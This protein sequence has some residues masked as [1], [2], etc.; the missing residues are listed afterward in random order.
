MEV[1]V[2]V[3]TALGMEADDSARAGQLVEHPVHREAIERALLFLAHDRRKHRHA[4][5][6]EVDQ[7]AEGARVEE[8]RAD[9]EQ[10]P[11]A[12]AGA[13]EIDP[14]DHEEVEE[15]PVVRDHH[16]PILVGDVCDPLHA[17]ALD[18]APSEEGQQ[19]Q[20]EGA[21]PDAREDPKLPVVEVRDSVGD[22]LH[23]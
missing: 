3:A 9:R 17:V 18:P 23:R 15:R 21:V 20:H 1:V 19:H 22:A 8:G 6:R 4:A 11:A 2:F 13:G 16:H 7:H 5:H 12:D 10:D 14:E